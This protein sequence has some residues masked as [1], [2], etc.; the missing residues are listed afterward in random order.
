MGLYTLRVQLTHSLKPR[1]VSTLELIEC[2]NRFQAFDY[3]TNVACSATF[4]PTSSP[5]SR[6][7]NKKQL[8]REGRRR[9]DVQPVGLVQG[10]ECT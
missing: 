5:Y 9:R 1:P 7:K 8:E 10:A 4:R 3:F 2:K 6:S